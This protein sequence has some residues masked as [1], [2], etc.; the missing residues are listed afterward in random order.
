MFDRWCVVAE[1]FW[2]HTRDDYWAEFLEAYCYAR[3]GLGENPIEVAL[4]RAKAGPLP[5]VPGFADERVRL[6]AAICR[7]IHLLTGSNPFFLPTRKLGEV[8][9]VDC[10]RA[11][12]WL[13]ALEGLRVIHLAPGEVRKRGGN[14]SPRYH[15]GPD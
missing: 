8:L 15:Y 5:D 2:R 11:A 4:S 9:G 6:L 1:R 3:I 13:R 12:Q 7:E 14:R 10:S